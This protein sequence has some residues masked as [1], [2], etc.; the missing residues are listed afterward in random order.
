MMRYGIMI[1]GLLAF[2][3][4]NILG[5][6]RSVSWKRTDQPVN[7]DLELFHS[8]H[9]ISLPTAE[10]H[11]KGDFE[12]EV[13]HRFFPPISDG[14]DELY[15]LDGPA[16]IRFA[17]GY[18]ITNRLM[19]VLGRSNVDNNFDLQAKYKAL[20]LK[21]NT[22]PV[23]TAIRVGAAWN[24]VR[25]SYFDSQSNLRTR[26]RNHKRN[27]QYYGQLI[28]NTL[29]DKKIGLGLIPSYLI[30]RDIRF[31]N[32]ESSFLLGINTQVYFMRHWSL[33]SDWVIIM[34]DK[35]DRYNQ[36]AIGMELETGG[37]FFKLFVTNQVLL[38][39]S[40]YLAGAQFPFDNDKLRLGFLV[41]RLL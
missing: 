18:S 20:Q 2:T 7:R 21:F 23:L 9:S 17:L 6:E 37:H 32:R 12:F 41:T 11:Q 16:N 5:Q 14:L 10:T 22:I 26:H 34:S 8:T 33:L 13:S 4:T 29:I 19:V 15:G 35:Y 30:N 1:L 40:Q 39:P 28:I 38:N 36:G 31:E 27:F 3:A 25:V 24:R